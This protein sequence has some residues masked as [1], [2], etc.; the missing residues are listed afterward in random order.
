MSHK[1][2]GGR[3]FQ[4]RRST[5]SP[6]VEEGLACLVSSGERPVWADSSES[7]GSKRKLEPRG[8]RDYVTSILRSQPG[9]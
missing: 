4:T 8:N 7:G 5:Q 3:T 6:R 2:L 9:L 1:A